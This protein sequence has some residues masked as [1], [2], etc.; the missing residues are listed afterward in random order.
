M[1]NYKVRLLFAGGT[2]ETKWFETEWAAKSWAKGKIAK[3]R[4]L[5]PDAIYG[6]ECTYYGDCVFSI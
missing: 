2:W 3:A 1:N 6:A 5:V 4:L